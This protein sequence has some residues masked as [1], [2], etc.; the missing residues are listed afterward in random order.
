MR[1]RDK[2]VDQARQS[3][4][5]KAMLHAYYTTGVC[6]S[7]MPPKPEVYAKTYLAIRKT[8]LLDR[9][10]DRAVLDDW[11]TINTD[12][13]HEAQAFIQESGRW[14]IHNLDNGT[15]TSDEYMEWVEQEELNRRQMREWRKSLGME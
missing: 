15:F 11:R 12:S 1:K 9:S 13:L 8:H 4:W 3:R 10:T 2:I 5:L 14:Y 6:V 7:Y